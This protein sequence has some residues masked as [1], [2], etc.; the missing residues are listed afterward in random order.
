MI[1][2]LSIFIAL[3]RDLFLA[4]IDSLVTGII[5][6]DMIYRDYIIQYTLCSHFPV[7]FLVVYGY[8][9]STLGV[10][11]YRVVF[12]LTGT[13]LKSSQYN[14]NVKKLGLEFYRIH[15]RKYLY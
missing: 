10:L 15:N 13:P 1:L 2:T 9:A 4:I 7:P 12:F 11:T 6:N 14:V 5:L 3:S 8:Y